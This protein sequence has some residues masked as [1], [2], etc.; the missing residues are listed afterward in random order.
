M[1]K[2]EG[3][4]GAKKREAM[5]IQVASKSHS[6]WRLQY[7]AAN[8]DKPRI[9]TTKDADFIKKNGIDQ[10]D[11]AALDFVDL[12][13]DWQK[14]NRLGAEVAVDAVLVAVDA[15]RKLDAA[16]I[17]EAS[18]VCHVK[19]LERNSEWATETQKLPYVQLPEDEK[20]KDRFFVRAA[21]EAYD[22]FR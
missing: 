17:E 22:S 9:K 14:E 6:E 7:K 15:R 13:S 12:P 16:F 5:I 11:I 19:W 3:S 8:G 10:V 4:E 20:E 21:I 2:I 18:A 1:R